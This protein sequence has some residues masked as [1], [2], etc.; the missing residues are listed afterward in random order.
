MRGNFPFKFWCHKVLPLVYDDSLSYYE[1]LCKLAKEINDI[2][3][4]NVEQ[5]KA[6]SNNNAYIVKLDNEVHNDIVPHL[7]NEISGLETAIANEERARIQGDYEIGIRLDKDEEN[8]T[9]LHRQIKWV[10][11][12]FGALPY[13]KEHSYNVGDFCL[14]N[15][16]GSSEDSTLIYGNIYRCKESTTGEFDSTKWEMI[17][18]LQF[19][20]RIWSKTLE[21]F[22]DK[23]DED[24]TWNVDDIV[25]YG[26]DEV[27]GNTGGMPIIYRCINQTT[28]AFN[29]NDWTPLRFSWILDKALD[30]KNE[31]ESALEKCDTLTTDYQNLSNTVTGINQSLSGIDTK[32]F[33]GFNS[34]AGNYQ[35]YSG[36]PLFYPKDSYVWYSDILYKANADVTVD[37]ASVLPP[38]QNSSWDTVKLTDEIGSGGSGSFDITLLAE[39]YDETSTYDYGECVSKD[40]KLYVCTATTATGTWDISK[41]E[42]TNAEG[43]FANKR[44]TM[45]ELTELIA[46]LSGGVQIDGATKNVPKYTLGYFAERERSNLYGRRLFYANKATITGSGFIQQDWTQL[47]NVGLYGW[48]K[49][50]TDDISR[51]NETQTDTITDSIEEVTQ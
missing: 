34:I 15:D 12:K 18:L 30:A 16:V 49:L 41:W 48:V 42:E 28:G 33:Y 1:F 27:Y 7:E 36:T 22:A 32:V 51:Y 35:E 25:L 10:A 19:V 3:E 46:E 43:A 14:F 24:H 31:A 13:D 6:I 17:N 37:S 23:Y 20:E 8:I 5:D 2:S 21:P 47:L 4:H 38:D 26:G 11:K 45:R 50:I 39:N 40:G 29:Y 9:D 44:R